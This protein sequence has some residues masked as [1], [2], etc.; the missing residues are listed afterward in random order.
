MTCRRLLCDA[1]VVPFLED[2]A[3]QT[4]DVGRKTRTIPAALRRAL[5][6]RDRG[7]RFPGC[8]HVRFLDAHHC[9]H[10]I[11][12]GET[13]LSNLQLLCRLHHGRVHEL[14]F[15]IEVRD[16]AFVF[17]DRD[18]REI[19]AAAARPPLAEGSFE[20]LRAANRRG[21]VEISAETGA[22][23]WDGVAVDYDSCVAA[24]VS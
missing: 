22:P 21:G 1:G 18:G 12:G 19:P 20:R 8:T 15:S 11:D 17:L 10:W 24:L 4:I 14:G 2:A 6:A 23:G 3:G 16:G 5:Q 9:R 13:K 7:C